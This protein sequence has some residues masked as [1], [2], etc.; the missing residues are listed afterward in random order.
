MYELFILISLYGKHENF[1]TWCAHT[2]DGLWLIYQ[3]RVLYILCGWT[4][5]W[6]ARTLIKHASHIS[7]SIAFLRTSS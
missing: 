6:S 4:K 2:T 1:F 3:C 5:T 7:Y